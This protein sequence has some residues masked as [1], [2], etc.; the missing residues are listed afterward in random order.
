MKQLLVVVDYQND[1]VTGALGFAAAEKLETGIAAAVAETLQSDGC[2]LFTRDTHKEGYLETREGKFLPVPHC[3]KGTFGHQLFG[4]LHQYETEPR[5]GVTIVDKTTF[6]CPLLAEE[7]KKLC[8]GVPAGITLCGVVTNICV[9][10]NA[11]ILQSA[12][13]EVPIRVYQNL[14]AAAPGAHEEALRMLQGLGIKLVDFP[15][16]TPYKN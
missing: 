2:V 4:S 14:T 6:G 11:V 16:T 3:V 5:P 7:A 15:Q 8:G 12:F 10:S 13:E 1:F 9:L